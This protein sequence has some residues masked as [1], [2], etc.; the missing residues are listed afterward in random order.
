MTK[1]L[2]GTGA[3]P[4]SPPLRA[5]DGSRSVGSVRMPLFQQLLSWENVISAYSLSHGL[6]SLRRDPIEPLAAARSQVI[7]VA[8][9]PEDRHI[10]TQRLPDGVAQG[11]P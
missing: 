2:E 9:P 5:E 11:C 10:A 6:V 7:E 8:L 3:P 1:H 4:L